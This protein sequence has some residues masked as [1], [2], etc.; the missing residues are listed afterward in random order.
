LDGFTKVNQSNEIFSGK[1]D[2]IIYWSLKFNL[3]VNQVSQLK[4]GINN[5][6]LLS[7]SFGQKLKIPIFFIKATIFS[8]A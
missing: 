7:V 1:A 3:I 5:T 4:F 2:V 6:W 8:S